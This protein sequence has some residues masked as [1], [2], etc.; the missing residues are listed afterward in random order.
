MVPNGW[1]QERL[2]N[3]ATFRNG[4]NFTKSDSGELVKIVGVGD[5]KDFSELRTTEHLEFINV[6]NELRQEDL[7]Q[8]GDLLF[9]R[10]NGNKELIGRCLYFPEVKEKLSFS[11]FTIRGR[12]ERNKILPEY[13]AYLVRSSFVRRQITENGGGT[14]ISNL[15][16]Q[17]LNDIVFGLPPLS[18]QQKI[19]K[20]LSTWDKAISATEQLISHSQQQKKVLIQALITGKKRL[21][22]FSE[23]W[24]IGKI[25]DFISESRISG[26]SGDIAKKITIKLY[27]KGVIPK[28]E[29]RLGS[30]STKYF[31]RKSGQF[32]YSKLDFLN[33]AFGIIPD[34][35]DGYESTLDLPAFDFKD[36]VC[37][38]WFVYFVSRTDFYSSNLGLANGGRK[39]RRVNPSDFLNINLHKPSLQEQ[40]K[41]AQVLTAAD[42]EIELL[43]QKLAGLKQ[44]KQ[45]LM[46]Q[47]LTGK[48]CVVV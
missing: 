19:A 44:E 12:V 46:Q 38:S 42:R 27:G 14:N 24:P 4:L 7:L 10:S 6:S 20:I 41:I 47:L 16:Q 36:G 28:D 32:I 26:S 5:F 30:G 15:S 3:V 25:S 39:A 18:E 21:S 11:G 2:E 37:P 48:R 1:T 35:L 17:I 45:A 8:S 34:E 13:A 31:I 9:V 33:G 40:Q 29:K 22:D 23:K 43:Q